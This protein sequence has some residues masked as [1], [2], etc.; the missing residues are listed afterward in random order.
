MNYKKELDFIKI[1]IRQACEIYSVSSSLVIS[2]KAE[3]DL[4]TDIDYKI[5]AFIINGIREY[6]PDDSILSEETLSTQDILGRT[7]TVDPIDGTCNMAHGIPIYGV[8]CSL[9]ENNEIV[10]SAIY[11]SN[12]D[13]MYTTTIN[14]GS[15]RNENRISV[16]H[17]STIENAIISF[18]D[19]SHNNIPLADKQH[20]AIGNLYKKI[21]KVRF[22]GAACF[23]FSYVADGKTDGAVVLTN[24]LWDI[25]PGI[26]LAK[27]AG[28]V[29]TNIYGNPYS[30]SDEGVVVAANQ[31]ISDLLV[32]MLTNNDT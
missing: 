4:V 17:K 19:Y 1:R 26:L 12:F 28:A 6:F 21:A 15:Y 25:A 11:L 3:H 27:E 32:S 22:W 20:A 13:D 30:F 24:N 14:T 23:D 9:I 5:E 10:A 29:I 31:E 18:G 8:Q 7:W 2:Q 16:S